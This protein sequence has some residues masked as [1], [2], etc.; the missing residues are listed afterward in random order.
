ME[1]V[2]DVN[3]HNIDPGKR[4]PDEQSAGKCYGV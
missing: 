4:V 3:R 1:K 2:Y